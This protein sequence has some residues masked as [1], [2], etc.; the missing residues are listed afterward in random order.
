MLKVRSIK[1]K[2]PAYKIALFENIAL[3]H[4]KKVSSTGNSVIIST[5]WA[6]LAE[7]DKPVRA[8]GDVG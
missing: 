4:I 1:L 5:G 2:A 7:L 3:R 8:V 6:T